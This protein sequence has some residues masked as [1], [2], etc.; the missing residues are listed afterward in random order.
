MAS[1]DNLKFEPHTGRVRGLVF[2]LVLAAAFALFYSAWTTYR[3]LR[4]Y[5]E[6]KQIGRGYDSPVNEFHPLLGYAPIPGSRAMDVFPFGYRIPV[7]HDQ[8]R[9]RAPTDA[10][11]ERGRPFVLALGCSFTY[12]TAC[13]AEDTFAERVAAS[14]RG[15]ALNA[16]S[17]GYGLAQMLVRARDLI[18]RFKPDLVLVQY[19][20]WLIARSLHAI[21]P[22]EGGCPV[23]GPYFT[24]DPYGH[25]T[26]AP[27][28]FS[29][30]YYRL[31]IARYLEGPACATQFVSFLTHAGFPLW[32]GSDVQMMRFRLKQAFGKVPPVANG[33][34][35]L[36]EFAYA[37]IATLCHENNARMFI[38]I[39]GSGGILR[40]DLPKGDLLALQ[41]VENADVVDAY[42]ALCQ[43]LN[44][45][46]PS[47]YEK[48]YGIWRGTPPQLIDRHPN[49]AAHAVIA[50]E[51]LRQVR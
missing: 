48:A 16:G 1:F 28:P 45:P 35:N 34:P 7:L 40:D 41:Q 38:V 6:M 26:V 18:P 17:P 24:Q 11:P 12:G 46:T 42:R 49:A 22:I 44:P 21:V 29:T 10:P 27:P 2:V 31:P 13:A 15:T 47:E 33:G 20:P 51:I 25:Y 14:L 39:L 19:S 43:R 30:N 4:F 50:E 3:S 9:L 37:E 23:P 36:T 5:R 8:D 32:A